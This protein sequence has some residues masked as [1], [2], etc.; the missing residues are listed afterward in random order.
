MMKNLQGSGKPLR[1]RFK[2]GETVLGTTMDYN[3]N[4]IGFFL[5]PANPDSNNERI[6]VVN[7]QVAEVEPVR[8]G[9]QG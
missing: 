1:V 4:A 8:V 3:P 9:A 6:Y 5:F 2:D 7:G